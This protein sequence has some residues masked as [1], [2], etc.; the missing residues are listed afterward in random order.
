MSPSD[1]SS[2]RRHHG[3]V[4]AARGVG[5]DGEALRPYVPRL[6]VE[7][8]RDRPVERWREVDGTARLRRHLRLHHA[9][10]A[11]R[12]QGPDRR[13][14]DERHPQRDLRGAAGGRVRGRRRAGE[15]GRRRGAA[16]LR[17]RRPRAA[18]G[19]G[20]VPD[21][22]GPAR[23]R[24]DQ[25]RRP[26]RHAADVGGRPQRDL[27]LLPRRR[28]R[29]ATASCSSAGR[30]RAARPRS[31]RSRTRGRDR[32]QRG[33]RRAAASRLARGRPRAGLPADGEP[34]VPDRSSRRPCHRR[35]GSTS[36]WHVS[37]RR[38]AST[39]WP[40]AASPSTAR[41]PWRSSSSPAPTHLLATGR[42]AGAGRRA[43]RV[44]AQ[45]PG[46]LPPARRHLLRDRHQRRRRQDH[47]GRRGA[48]QRWPQRGAAAAGD[49]ADPR[50]TGCAAAA[51]RGQRAGRS[52]PATSAR[53][54]AVRTR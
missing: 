50:P 37:A 36:G 3:T 44:R 14:G 22:A 2:D 52:S 18:R 40:V 33:D 51:R 1:R 46:G 29:A 41:S 16:A 30:R 32:P 39:C 8:L 6:L 28:P 35:T 9:D 45:R 31:R 11:A 54:S 4:A 19:A 10:R 48:A 26:A 25:R 43:R 7:W 34:E 42:A 24:P 20:G 49:P 5:G 38:S 12:P 15:V 53:R 23:G 21:A 17:G 27:P 13:R 47:A